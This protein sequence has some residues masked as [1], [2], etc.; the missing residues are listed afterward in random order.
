MFKS[1]IVVVVVVVVVV[2]IMTDLLC[3]CLEDIKNF[4][5]FCKHSLS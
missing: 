5:Y 3:V 1:E 2:V 4:S